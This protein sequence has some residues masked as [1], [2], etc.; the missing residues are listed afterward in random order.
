[1]S[2]VTDGLEERIA[3]ALG[4]ARAEL[5][6][7]ASRAADREAAAARAQAH[8]LLAIVNELELVRVELRELSAWYQEQN[9]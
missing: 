4:E 6:A 9:P 5:R 1:L 2:R 3:A 7:P 8:A